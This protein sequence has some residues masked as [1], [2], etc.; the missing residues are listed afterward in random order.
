VIKTQY[1]ETQENRRR[2][3]SRKL[4][5]I[6]RK[7]ESIFLVKGNALLLGSLIRE[8][9]DLRECLKDVEVI[10]VERGCNNEC[11]HL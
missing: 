1:I 3:L 7:I 8:A 10:L 2:E 9:Q 4:D 11:H 6:E 5:R